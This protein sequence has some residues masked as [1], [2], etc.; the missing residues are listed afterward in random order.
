MSVLTRVRYVV[1][2]N[3]NALLERAENPEKLLAALVREMEDARDDAR[4]AITELLT[5]QRRQQRLAL[6]YQEALRRWQD[7]AEQAVSRQEERLARSALQSRSE[8]SRKMEDLHKRQ[9]Q[10][11]D[12]ISR[13]EQAMQQ[14]DLKLAEARNR[15]KSMRQSKHS[16]PL[17]P[18]GPTPA[19]QRTHQ[20]LAR[21]D[22]V[23]ERIEHL[24]A[25]VAA[26][27]FG[28][29][30]DGNPSHEGEIHDPAI[31]LELA[32]LKKRIGQAE[33]QE[34]TERD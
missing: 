2:A 25:R 17:N 1:A 12:Q 9:A 3:I 31:E 30:P 27:E 14:L 19:E 18:G 8:I 11:R 24:E 34:A 6:E 4:P 23:Q 20:A 33:G 16:A 15:L 10:T 26:Y 7:K 5:Q 32:S 29:A 22:R 13:L 21:F 28:C